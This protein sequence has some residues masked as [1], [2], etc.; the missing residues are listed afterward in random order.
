MIACFQSFFAYDQ[1]GNGELLGELESLAK[2]LR[3]GDGETPA[4]WGF[5][6]V[7]GA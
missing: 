6:S 5:E 7:T 1:P 3:T 4:R 2:A